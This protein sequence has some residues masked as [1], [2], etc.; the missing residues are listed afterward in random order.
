MKHKVL[1][2]C[3]GGIYG[4]IS[5]KFLSYL[6]YDF[7]QDIDTIAGTSIGGVQS[8]CYASGAT[9]E[10]VLKAFEQEGK[11]IFKKRISS[12]IN[13]LSIP[14]YENE[15]LKKMLEKFILN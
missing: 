3:G 1:I 10:E 5:S 11:N 12:K 4:A 15:N 9:G 2:L 6:D 7:I 8:C 13:P 14:T